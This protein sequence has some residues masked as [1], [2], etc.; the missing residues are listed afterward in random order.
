MLHRMTFDSR[1]DGTGKADLRLAARAVGK[2]SFKF[3]RS[4]SNGDTSLSF[5]GKGGFE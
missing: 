2:F 1:F 4:H 5:F 3:G